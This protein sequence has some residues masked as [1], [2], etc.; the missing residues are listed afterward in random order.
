MSD[1]AE[2][3]EGRIDDG[4]S[5]L[6]GVASP[7]RRAAAA[8]PAARPRKKA[9]SVKKSNG[10]AQK[11]AKGRKPLRRSQSN[12]LKATAV[13]LLGT[14]GGLLLIPAVWAVLVLAGVAVPAADREDSRPMAA[15]MLVSWPIAICLIWAAVYFH[16]QV[17]KAKRRAEQQQ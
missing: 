1:R 4:R 13:P 3:I 7:R 8:E 15:I 2:W 17:A 5:G 11:V 10:S 6:A 16:F 14:V 9:P 12:D